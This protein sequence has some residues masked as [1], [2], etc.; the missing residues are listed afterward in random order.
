MIKE[1]TK[2]IDKIFEVKTSVSVPYELS[3]NDEYYEDDIRFLIDEDKA[4][5]FIDNFEDENQDDIYRRAKEEAID[6]IELGELKIHTSKK[7]ISVNDLV[8]R[9]L[10][11]YDYFDDDNKTPKENYLKKLNYIKSELLGTCFENKT[12]NIIKT[13]INGEQEFVV[14]QKNC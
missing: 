4:Q 12:A 5:S 10:D 13:E 14:I 9:K 1:N 8:K 11:N 7:E 6:Q 3:Y 2:I